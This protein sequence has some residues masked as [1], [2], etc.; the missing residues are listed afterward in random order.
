MI[1]SYT[2]FTA[3]TVDVIQVVWSQIYDIQL[4]NVH[5]CNSW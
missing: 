1:F 3:V 4:R 2:M 5:D